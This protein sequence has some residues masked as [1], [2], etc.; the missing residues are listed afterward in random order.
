MGR[1]AN[2]ALQNIDDAVGTQALPGQ[3]QHQCLQLFRGQAGL[4]LFTLGPD[5]VSLVQPPGSQPDANAVMLSTVI[6]F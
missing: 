5:E 2:C 4:C 3:A 1:Y 6:E